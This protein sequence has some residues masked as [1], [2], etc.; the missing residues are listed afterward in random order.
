[1]PHAFSGLGIEGKL[2]HNLQFS[3]TMARKTWLQKFNNGQP[4]QITSIDKVYAG[5]PPGEKFLISSPSEIDAYVRQ[6]P[7]GKAVSFQT[8][9]RDLALNHQ[10]EHICPLTAGI[11]TRIAAELAFEQY[12]NGMDLNSIMPFWRVVDTKT[13]F[14]AKLA[15]GLD[16][17]ARQREAEG[18]PLFISAPGKSNS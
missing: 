4:P 2:P 1:M 16:F 3:T 14:A 6:I 17:I 10:I 18:L 5:I 15:C 9:K 8:M 7:F 12:T 11:F 13:P